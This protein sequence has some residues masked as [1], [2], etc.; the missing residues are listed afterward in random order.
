MSNTTPP[1]V[2]SRAQD[3]FRN[4]VVAGWKAIA[5]KLPADFTPSHLSMLLLAGIFFSMRE[6]IELSSRG[7][8]GFR[9]VPF[10]LKPGAPVRILPKDVNG[11]T[12][13]VVVWVDSLVGLPDAVIRLGTSN[14]SPLAG[15]VRVTSGVANEMGAV[16][17]N[18]ELWA[19]TDVAVNIYVIEET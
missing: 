9:I 14:G 3:Y 4:T 17:A 15:G 6:F 16:P 8:N 2:L 10:A 7:G 13:R 11:R 18:V 5:C 12:R 1:T 19:A